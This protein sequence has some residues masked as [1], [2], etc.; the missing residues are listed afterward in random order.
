MDALFRL[1]ILTIIG[2]VLACLGY[3]ALGYAARRKEEKRGNGGG[4]ARVKDAPPVKSGG[5]GGSRACPLCAAAL[6]HGEQ[7]KSTAFPGFPGQ[8]RIMHIRGC[9]YCL[10]G[11][12][13][14]A[15]PVCGAAIGVDEV[16]VARMFNKPGRSHVHVLGCSR[17]RL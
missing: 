5:S 13:E 8:G 1:L 4:I 15:C 2:A 11:S 16:L 17:C 9:A 14:R 12:R 3:V 7:V 6:V 10:D